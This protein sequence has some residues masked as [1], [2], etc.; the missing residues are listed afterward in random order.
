MARPLSATLSE[1]A[2]R[3]NLMRV[4]HYAPQSKVMAMVKA[5]GYGHGLLQVAKALEGA[6]A[7]G[8]ACI[9]EALTL[10]TAGFKQEIVLIEG[11]FGAD[12]ISVVAQYGLTQVIHTFDQIDILRSQSVP[13]NTF[14][15]W[16]KV[17]TGMNRLGFNPD[18]FE[19]AYAA[20][21]QIPSVSRIGFMTQFVKADERDAPLTHEQITLF[22]SIIG[23]KPGEKCLANSAGILGWPDSHRDWVRPGIM[24]YGAA[25]FANELG[26]TFDLQPTLSLSTQ[27]I[28]LHT[29]KKGESV[30][31]SGQWQ[32]E[33][34]QSRIATLAM[35][36]GDGYPR[37]APN[38]TPV[39][40][41]QQRAFLV[42]RVSMDMVA[43]DVTDVPSVQVG[44][45][46]TLWGGD[47]PVE[48]VARAVGTLPNEL[49]CRCTNGRYP[50]KIQTGVK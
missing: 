30:G 49:F 37:Q 14:A 2:L 32:S 16:L 50:I 6:D 46:V 26:S 8:V 42:G 19:A 23:D 9:E 4:R 40:V 24:L 25:P 12:E 34:P 22:D 44:D 10:R 45:R 47:L 41:N 7:F 3:H 31:Y 5:N 27:I 20:L 18:E 28:A 38:G 33:R 1:P 43:I 39:L 13:P 48:E 36:Y 11:I 21:S 35:G 29:V 15:V 17:N